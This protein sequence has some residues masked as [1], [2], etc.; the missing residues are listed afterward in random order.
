VVL[1]TVQVHYLINFL[2]KIEVLN[3]GKIMPR[4]NEKYPETSKVSASRQTQ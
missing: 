3:R 4:H 2:N 1:E